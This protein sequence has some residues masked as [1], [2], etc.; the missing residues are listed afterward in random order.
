MIAVPVKSLSRA[1]T[2]LS[3]VLT[4]LERAALTLAMLEDVLDAALSV[5]AD[6]HDLVVVVLAVNDRFRLDFAVGW[7]ELR[8]VLD[9]PSNDLTIPV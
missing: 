9:Q 8:V 7:L 6:V 5:P 2:R 3:R 4:P 1:K